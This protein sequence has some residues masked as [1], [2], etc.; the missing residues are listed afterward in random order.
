MSNSCHTFVAIQEYFST[1]IQQHCE[2]DPHQKHCRKTNYDA[3]SN[4]IFADLAQDGK[5]LFS[6]NCASCHAVHKQLTGPALAGVEDRW[7]EKANLLAWIRNSQAYLKTGDKYA[8]DLYA[9]Y[10]KTQMNAFPALT[11]QDIDAILA[12][13]KSVP[14]PGAGPVTG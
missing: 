4:I 8:N 6:Q 13:I 2:Y 7:S 14:A 5:A 1:S 11:D 12:Y 3:C 9:Q 10:N